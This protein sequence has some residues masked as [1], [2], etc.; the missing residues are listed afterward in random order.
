MMSET[1]RTITQ[2]ER[3]ANDGRVT[4]RNRE[5]CEAAA[6]EMKQIDQIFEQL[7]AVIDALMEEKQALEDK[8]ADEIETNES[9]D[10]KHRDNLGLAYDQMRDVM[11]ERDKARRLLRKAKMECE[12][13]TVNN[14]ALTMY[15]YSLKKTNE[16]V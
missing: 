11:E 16:E 12:M 13:R 1:S 8:L 4:R 10:E 3:I 2:L 5:I 7:N 9:A 14:E 15:A 6:S